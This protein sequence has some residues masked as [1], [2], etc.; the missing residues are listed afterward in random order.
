MP[1]G[2]FDKKT[3]AING[4]GRIGRCVLRSYLE[5]EQYQQQFSI[6]AINEL[7]DSKT[8]LHLL[9][10]DSVHGRL[11]FSA[12]LIED[13]LLV[14]ETPVATHKIRLQQSSDT[15]NLDW[16]NI[17]VLLECSGSFGDH[18]TTLKHLHQGA[19]KLL[20][21]HP[22]SDVD[23]TIVYGVNEHSLMPEH[24]VVSNGSC[25]TNAITPVLKALMSQFDIVAGTTT[26]LHSVM[27]DQPVIDAYHHTDLRKTRASAVSMIPVD[28]EL[29]KGIAKILPSLAG[30]F[31]SQAIRIPTMNVSALDVT[32]QLGQAVTAQQINACLQAHASDILAVTA[33][34]L[35]SCDFN[36]DAHSV[37][38]DA[39]QTDVAGRHLVKLL[40]WFDNEWS[41]ASRMLD[42]AGKM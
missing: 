16:Q 30:K 26:T 17:D 20:F 29:D 21:S 33:E 1:K 19:K 13:D 31:T 39:S 36:H 32:L 14:I 41:F 27:N 7:A 24:T 34:P 42:V 3:L 15:I 10:Y 9:K 5:S 6:A 25:T 35:A 28:T 4:F 38:V 18:G 11:P 40:L 8:V 2:E 37:I 12:N 23:A 22:A